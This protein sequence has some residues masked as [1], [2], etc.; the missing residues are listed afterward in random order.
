MKESKQ[1]RETKKNERKQ[2]IKKKQQRKTGRKEERTAEMATTNTPRVRGS[3][4]SG[5]EESKTKVLVRTA[6]EGAV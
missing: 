5:R 4:Y 1:H 6:R 2:D 3:G